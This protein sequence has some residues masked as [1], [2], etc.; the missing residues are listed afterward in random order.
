MAIALRSPTE[1]VKGL[2]NIELRK[3]LY[4]IISVGG[5]GDGR[6]QFK[7]ATAAGM[8]KD[9]GP[10]ASGFSLEDPPTLIRMAPNKY[11]S[12]MLFEGIHFKMMIDGTIQFIDR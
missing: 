11:L 5:E 7:I 12:Q 4:T 10:L 2:S 8:K 1:N 9:L 6:A 3:R